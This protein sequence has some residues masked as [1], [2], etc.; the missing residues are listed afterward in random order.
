MTTDNVAPLYMK[1]AFLLPN[2]R[3]VIPIPIH[4]S[5]PIHFV[6]LH[7]THIADRKIHNIHTAYSFDPHVHNNNVKASEIKNIGTQA[8]I[9]YTNVTT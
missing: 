2:K 9:L 4:F 6:S 8:H 7:V 1:I 3:F 5:L